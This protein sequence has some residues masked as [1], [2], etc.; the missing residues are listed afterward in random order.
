MS[1]RV[2]TWNLNWFPGDTPA[3]SIEKQ[4]AQI[5]EVAEV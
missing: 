4:N 1:V 3:V 2:T 5:K